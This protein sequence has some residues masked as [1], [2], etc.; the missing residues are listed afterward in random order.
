[1]SRVK[2]A[3]REYRRNG[4]PV[5]GAAGLSLW[6]GGG[7]PAA[8]GVATADTPT[9][10]VAVNHEQT[11]R[12]EEITDM[13]LSTFHIFDRERTPRLLPRI[14]A[15]ACV[16]CAASGEQPAYNGSGSGMSPPARKPTH[17]Y[18][19]T[20]KRSPER[21][22]TLRSQ[23]FKH[24]DQSASR[25]QR[26]VGA[27]ATNQNATRQAQPELDGLVVNQSAGQQAQPQ[28]ATPVTNSAN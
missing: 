15:G 3:L 26:E 8:M 28:M 6:L 20:L 22:Q 25:S 11:L 7:A 4:V 2:A 18:V 9:C 27:R 13:T 16:A 5:L 21:L 10:S 24:Q 19:Q 14:A 12:E 1:M 17:P 23:T